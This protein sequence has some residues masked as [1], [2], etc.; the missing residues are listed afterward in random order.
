MKDRIIRLRLFNYSAEAELDEATLNTTVSS[1]ASSGYDGDEEDL[2]EMMDD[3]DEDEAMAWFDDELEEIENKSKPKEKPKNIPESLSTECVERATPSFLSPSWFK[4]VVDQSGLASSRSV[5]FR[6]N[7]MTGESGV[8][9]PCNVSTP[10]AVHR[11]PLLDVNNRQH[12]SGNS[13]ARK[14]QAQFRPIDN[15]PSSEK[16]DTNC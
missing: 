13:A 15:T 12:V 2:G 5:S 11:R 10:A 6:E 3:S 1:I 14:A 8:R 9:I 7:K 4:D 16:M